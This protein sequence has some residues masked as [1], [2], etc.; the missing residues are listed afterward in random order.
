[1]LCVPE[2]Q[3]HL[4]FLL[5]LE[6]VMLR[7]RHGR[8][9]VRSD[10][11][12]NRSLSSRLFVDPGLQS[13]GYG[14]QDLVQNRYSPGAKAR[15]GPTEESV[16]WPLGSVKASALAPPARSAGHGQHRDSCLGQRITGHRKSASKV[17]VQF[18]RWAAKEQF[19][20]RVA[21]CMITSV[22]KTEVSV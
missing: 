13:L 9:K 19:P 2:R 3:N 17:P 4:P 5:A 8:T 10:V 21:G 1:M 11:H 7:R 6:G 16:R 22:S 12:Q 14:F 15:L 20:K 18:L